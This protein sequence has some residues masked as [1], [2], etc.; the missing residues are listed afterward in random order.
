MKEGFKEGNFPSVEKKRLWRRRVGEPAVSQPG[1]YINELSTFSTE[2]STAEE[3]DLLGVRM[4]GY[5]NHT[6]Q[7]F[8][9]FSLCLPKSFI[10]CREL[11]DKRRRRLYNR[12]DWEYAQAM[13]GIIGF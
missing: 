6:E 9:P 8:S 5:V 1:Y 11:F 12:Y 10:F 7:L 13:I 2:L 4:R 3:K